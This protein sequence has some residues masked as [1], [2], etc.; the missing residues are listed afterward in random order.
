MTRTAEMETIC[1]PKS[2]G[3]VLTKAEIAN[4]MTK[5]PVF[6]E[7]CSCPNVIL[8]SEEYELDIW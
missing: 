1:I 4:V 2:M 8:S 3:S 5:C 6:Q 7:T